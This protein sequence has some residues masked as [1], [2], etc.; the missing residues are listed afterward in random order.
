MEE[1]DA[2]EEEELAEEED[3]EEKD[4]EEDVKE[5]ALMMINPLLWRPSQRT[6][7]VYFSYI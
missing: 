7:F 2:Q 6:T 3:V 1:D 4:V 5:G